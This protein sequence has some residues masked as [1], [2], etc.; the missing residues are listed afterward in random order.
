M[1]ITLTAAVAETGIER[2]AGRGAGSGAGHWGGINVFLAF[3]MFV[4]MELLHVAIHAL[5][6]HAIIHRDLDFQVISQ[7][8]L[9]FDLAK[10]DRNFEVRIGNTGNFV[11]TAFGHLDLCGGGESVGKG[12]KRKQMVRRGTFF[13]KCHKQDLLPR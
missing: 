12:R 7:V 6:D 9:K 11:E 10:N 13:L 4:A 2:H 5:L 3:G 8:S 1:T